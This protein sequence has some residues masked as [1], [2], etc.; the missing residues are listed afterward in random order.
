MRVLG[1]DP[2][3]W[4]TGWGLLDGSPSEPRLVDCGVIRLGKRGSFASR[5]SHLQGEIS[6]L[7]D[8]VRPELAAVEAPFH[9]A[10]ARAAL[11]LAHARGVVLAVLAGSGLEVAEYA[12]AA[13]KKAIT[14]NGRA[15]KRQVRK[16]VQA[17]LGRAAESRSN[18]VSDA[19][20]VS[21]CHL[22][23]HGFREAV[24]RGA[25]RSGGHRGQ[26]G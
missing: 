18:D 24:A 2:G 11:Q 10:S 25:G 16:M 6:D 9:G 4:N 3:S 5:L 17:L 22:S 1:I 20:A 7:V 19:L 12:P 13:V 26:S 21:L 14:G 8:R 23:C 15:D